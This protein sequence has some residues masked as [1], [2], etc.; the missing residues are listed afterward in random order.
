MPGY[1]VLSIWHC[2]HGVIITI[3]I[4]EYPW[5]YGR[6]PAVQTDKTVY[7]TVLGILFIY[8]FYNA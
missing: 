6:R 3:L 5:F 1:S 2:V 4:K 7:K 8:V